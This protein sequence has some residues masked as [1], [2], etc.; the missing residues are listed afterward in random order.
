[1]RVLGQPMTAIRIATAGEALIDLVAQPDGRMLPCWGGAAYNLAR[2]LA[3]QGVATTYL[4][5]F[6]SDRLGRQLAA[7]MLADG[8]VLAQTEPVKAVTSWPWWAWTR[9][10]TPITRFTAKAWPTGRSPPRH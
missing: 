2:A 4:N 10:A 3:L 7:R 8:V 1:M 6:S 5:P 9:T